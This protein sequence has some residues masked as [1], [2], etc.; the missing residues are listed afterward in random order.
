MKKTTTT[1]TSASTSKK[2]T[3]AA[4]KSTA[5]TTTKKVAVVKPAAKAAPKKATPAAVKKVEKATKAQAAADLDVASDASSP[6]PAAPKVVKEKVAPV[7]KP[8]KFGPTIN[9]ISKEQLHIWVFGEG[10]QGELGLGHMIEGNR[11]PI[12]VAR[13]RLNPILEEL[14]VVRIAVGGMHAAAITHDNKIYTWGVNDQGALGRDTTDN[15]PEEEKDDEDDSGLNPEEATPKAVESIYFPEGTV[16]TDLC[17]SDSAT[18]VVT[19][20][21]S[22]YG[23]GTFRVSLVPFNCPSPANFD[24]GR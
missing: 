8:H 14:G 24:L 6:A 18:F 19:E 10:S 11:E 17:C 16:L 4:T 21:G 23:W 20:D 5:K 2:S 9:K 15:R 13:P 12:D 7:P 1:K 22:V 3:P